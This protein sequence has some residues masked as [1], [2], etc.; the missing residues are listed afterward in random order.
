M[1]TQ[2][3]G[4]RAVCKARDS[5][6]AAREKSISRADG[7]HEVRADYSRRILLSLYVFKFRQ[8]YR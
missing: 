6:R 5:W 8:L 2:I 7:K 3:N 1:H 4:M